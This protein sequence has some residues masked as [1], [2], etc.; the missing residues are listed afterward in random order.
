MLGEN[1]VPAPSVLEQYVAED[2][3]RYGTKLA[4]MHT[5]LSRARREQVE[6]FEDAA[7]GKDDEL[8]AQDGE[9]LAA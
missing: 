5:K 1:G 3:E 4:D 7:E 2:V 8:L 9:V 6:G